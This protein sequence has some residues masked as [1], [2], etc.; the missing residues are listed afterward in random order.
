LAESASPS[1]LDLWNHHVR[2]AINQLIHLYV[3]RII[4]VRTKFR[5]V[6]HLRSP[7]LKTQWSFS[8]LLGAQIRT[9]SRKI[10]HFLGV[11]PIP[12]CRGNLVLLTPAGETSALPPATD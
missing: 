12:D 9:Q 1:P 11:H 8:R 4:V 6:N 3:N 2:T 10:H 5:A 7:L